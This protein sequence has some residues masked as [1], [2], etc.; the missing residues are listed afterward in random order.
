MAIRIFNPFSRT[1]I[2]E[3]ERNRIAKKRGHHLTA[4]ARLDAQIGFLQAQRAEHWSAANAY[5]EA[6][7]SLDE[8]AVDNV[9]ALEGRANG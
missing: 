2:L 3:R 6:E 1:G 8:P 5:V 7:F 9:I 4:V